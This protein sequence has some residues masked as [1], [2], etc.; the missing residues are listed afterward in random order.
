MST[1]DFNRITTQATT[2]SETEWAELTHDLLPTLDGTA[3]IAVAEAWDAE[4]LRRLAEV[5]AGTAQMVSR[6]E[7]SARLRRAVG[8]N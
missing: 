2:F 1:A 6:E 8:H 7:F 3:D 4:I 5:K